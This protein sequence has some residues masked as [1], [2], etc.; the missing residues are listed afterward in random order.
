M[1]E[2]WKYAL[3][4]LLGL[5]LANTNVLLIDSC[6]NKKD[7]KAKLAEVMFEKLKI[8]SLLMMNSSALSLFSTGATTG[9]V[10]ELG[11]GLSTV[12]PVFE[13]FVL[14]HALQ[15]SDVSG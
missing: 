10:A 2:L 4:E 13:G 1:S 8:N 3:T 11:H 9:F 14:P 6:S 7:Y 15:Q 12:I 5:E